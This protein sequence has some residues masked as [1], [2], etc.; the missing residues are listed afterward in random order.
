MISRLVAAVLM[1]TLTATLQPRAQGADT[2]LTT[3]ISQARQGDLDAAITTLNRAVIRLATEPGHTKDLGTA[4]LWTSPTRPRR[5]SWKG[6]AR[7]RR[8]NSIPPSSLRA[9]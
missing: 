7:I 3:G 4:Y 9:W 8:W 1:T 2:D 5:G 6:C